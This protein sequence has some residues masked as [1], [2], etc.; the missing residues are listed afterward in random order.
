MNTLVSLTIYRSINFKTAEE[1]I[2]SVFGETD[3]ML[4]RKVRT[5]LTVKRTS[6]IVSL[7]PMAEKDLARFGALVR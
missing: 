2:T 1:E 3:M 7:M 6:D 4:W 5:K